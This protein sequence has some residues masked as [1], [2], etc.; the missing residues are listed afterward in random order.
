MAFLIGFFV[1][2]TIF[3][4]LNKIFPYHGMGEYDEVDV[5][6]TLTTKEAVARGVVPSSSVEILEGLEAVSGDGGEKNLAAN[7]VAE[8]KDSPR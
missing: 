4:I 6:G 7:D 2:G 5:Y 8:T 1:S 3:Y